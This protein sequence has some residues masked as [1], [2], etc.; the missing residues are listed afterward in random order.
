[1]I[2]SKSDKIFQELYRLQEDHN[3][4]CIICVVYVYDMWYRDIDLVGYFGIDKVSCY[5]VVIVLLWDAVIRYDINQ[6]NKYRLYYFNYKY[7]LKV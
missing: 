7:D 1:M 4:Y 5:G 6:Y 3:S 2:D